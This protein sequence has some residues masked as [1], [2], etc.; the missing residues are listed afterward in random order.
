MSD[1]HP[2][3]IDDDSTY[4]PEVRALIRRAAEADLPVLITG[5][6][7]SGK[8]HVARSIHS[9]SR[10]ANAPFVTVNLAAVPPSLMLPELFG[11]TPDAFT[12]ARSRTGLVELAG[13]G[14]LYLDGVDETGLELHP[15]LLHLLDSLRFRRLGEDQERSTDVRFI[16]S[17]LHPQ[18]M[19]QGLR[20]RFALEIHLPSLRDRKEDLPKF[21]D[22]IARR[23]GL[24]VAFSKDALEELKRYDFPGDYRDLVNII[25]GAAL[26]A[27]GGVVTR[28]ALPKR[29]TEPT[30]STRLQ[31]ASAAQLD[32]LR[33]ELLNLRRT[34]LLADPIWQGR[35]FPTEGD[36]CFVLMA[37]ADTLDLQDVYAKHV[38]VVIEA[39]CGLRCERADDIY[40]ISGVMQSVWEGI[41]RARLVIADLTARNPN[42]FY[43]LGIAHTLGK[44]VIMI[45]QSMDF[46]PF[47]L[48]HLR[49]LVYEYK[50]GRIETFEAALEKTVRTVLSSTPPGARMEL[51]IE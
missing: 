20:S 45:T 19:N 31:E 40:G 10:R 7:G 18:S 43:E 1:E 44:P 32:V 27:A 29:V 47:D 26:S 46:V 15:V 39:R 50:P 22:K 33:K 6:R 14:T 35:N 34:A 9:L 13:G 24:Q 16:G 21:I 37:F 4:T 51:R 36:Y 17:A 41:N 30:S 2:D 11:N 8:D 25:R 23:L 28:E 5:R 38:K 3:E 48:R 12:G 49:C 42:V